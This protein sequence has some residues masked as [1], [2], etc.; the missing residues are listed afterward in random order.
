[1][2]ANARKD[3]SIP[4]LHKVLYTNSFP[5]SPT[6]QPFPCS[7]QGAVR[8]KTLEGVALYWLQYMLTVKTAKALE[9]GQRFS[10]KMTVNICKKGFIT[11]KNDNRL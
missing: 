6:F 2:L 7:S 5:G 10:L 1:M 9:V 8:W 11:P 3:H 4:L